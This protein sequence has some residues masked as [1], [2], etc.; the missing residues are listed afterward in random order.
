MIF[1]NNV[2]CILFLDLYIRNFLLCANKL[3]T[4]IFFSFRQ[5]YL[6]NMTILPSQPSRAVIL[7]FS[8]FGQSCSSSM[9][10]PVNP[11]R[12]SQCSGQSRRQLFFFPLFV[13]S[14]S[15]MKPTHQFNHAP[16]TGWETTAIPVFCYSKTSITNRCT[17]W[18]NSLFF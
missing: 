10:Y 17:L 6:R 7:T 13:S 16:F 9:V 5:D 4:A 1:N 8:S 15:P 18:Y 14:V 3:Y 2:S 12:N 11:A